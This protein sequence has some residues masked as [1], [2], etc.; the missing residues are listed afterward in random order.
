MALHVT[1]DVEDSSQWIVRKDGAAYGTQFAERRLA[2]NHAERQHLRYATDVFVH[3][4]D[5]TV[6]EHWQCPPHIA[7]VWRIRKG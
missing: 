6:K 4:T 2:M 3:N 1:P 5:G 7:A